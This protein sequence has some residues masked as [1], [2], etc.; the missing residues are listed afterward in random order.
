MHLK[1]KSP[2]GFLFTLTIEE[3]ATPG[4]AEQYVKKIR[5]LAAMADLKKEVQA[6]QQQA[7]QNKEQSQACIIDSITSREQSN[8]RP[9]L[10]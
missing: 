1:A 2:M 6:Q 10:L 3:G 9:I 7:Q 8:V 5:D 4:M